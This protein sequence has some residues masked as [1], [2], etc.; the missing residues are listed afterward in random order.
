M[1]WHAHWKK[2]EKLKKDDLADVKAI[3]FSFMPA[4]MCVCVCVVYY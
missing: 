3:S 4:C 1:H 2:I